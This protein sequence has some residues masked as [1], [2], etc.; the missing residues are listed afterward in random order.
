MKPTYN[1]ERCFCDK[2]KI[3]PICSKKNEMTKDVANIAL[4]LDDM[5]VPLEVICKCR[6][7]DIE[8]R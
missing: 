5:C 2:C 4:E 1:M 7:F 6:Y 8:S 3:E